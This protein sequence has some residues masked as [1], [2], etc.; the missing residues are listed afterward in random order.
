MLIDLAAPL[1]HQMC[2]FFTQLFSSFYE[3]Q[4]HPESGFVGF[5]KI[6]SC[7]RAATYHF[8]QEKEPDIFF[9]EN[10]ADFILSII[11]PNGHKSIYP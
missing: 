5:H 7:S 9:P 8:Q 6:V 3:H 10:T 11:G 4:L 1:E 2:S